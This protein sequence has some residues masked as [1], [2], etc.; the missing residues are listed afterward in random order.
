ML[1]QFSGLTTSFSED[2]SGLE[3]GWAL[4]TVVKLVNKVDKR[5]FQNISLE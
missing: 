5:V 1:A 3:V 4:E 2:V